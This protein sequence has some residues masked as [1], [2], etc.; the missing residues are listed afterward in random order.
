ME[1]NVLLCKSHLFT[2]G[3]HSV[4][5]GLDVPTNCP[6]RPDPVRTPKSSQSMLNVKV[7]CGN[8]GMKTEQVFVWGKPLLSEI[9]KTASSQTS[10][11][12]EHCPKDRLDLSEGFLFC[13]VFQ[14]ECPCLAQNSQNFPHT[15]S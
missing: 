3:K 5:L 15:H 9:L 10:R 13:L 14:P 6:P 11:I 2:S 4:F 7:H 8:I 12:L 1:F